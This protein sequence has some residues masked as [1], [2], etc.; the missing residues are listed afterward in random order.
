MPP[1]TR[2]P[3][4]L[5]PATANMLADTYALGPKTHLAAPLP[6]AASARMTSNPNGTTTHQSL[7]VS[8]APPPT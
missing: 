3:W 5:G 2:F 4:L 6:Q 8:M 1:A 7:R